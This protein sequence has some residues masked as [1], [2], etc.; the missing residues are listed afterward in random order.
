MI[1]RTEN[2]YQNWNLP[3]RNCSEPGLDRTE[4]L[5]LSVGDWSELELA[6]N[7]TI[8]NQDCS[9]PEL[10]RTGIG[11]NQNY[12]EPELTRTGTGRNWNWSEEKL[13]EI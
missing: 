6:R 3:N 7:E 10:V 1:S 11:K 9:G 13:V 8:Q 12:S 4:S 5:G 2:D